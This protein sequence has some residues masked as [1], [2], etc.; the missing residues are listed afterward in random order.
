MWQLRKVAV[1][2]SDDSQDDGV[3]VKVVPES[4]VRSRRLRDRFFP[5]DFQVM[6]DL[7]MSGATARQVAEKLSISLRSVKRLPHGRGVVMR[8]VS[9]PQNIKGHGFD[10]HLVSW[11]GC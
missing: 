6:I 4:V 2:L 7:Y 1:I 8:G 9:V 10:L 11:H 5:E 3:G